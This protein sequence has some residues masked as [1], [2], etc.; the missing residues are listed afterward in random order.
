MKRIALTWRLMKGNWK[1][2]LL[3][4]A[5]YKTL[6]ILCFSP[7][8]MALLSLSISLSG[9][10]YIA[11]DNILQ[12]L[13]NPYAVVILLLLAF[14]VAMAALIE[15]CA[16][17]Y[18][19]HA[20]YHGEKVRV[21]E[22][23]R[24]GLAHGLRVF[25]QG[26][27]LLLIYVVVMLPFL[28]FGART[29][30]IASLKIPEFIMEYIQ[31]N[32]GLFAAYLVFFAL[33]MLFAMRWL[34]SLHYYTISELTFRDARKRSAALMHKRTLKTVV[35]LCLWGVALGFASIVGTVALLEI[36]ILLAKL[37]TNG[38][39][40]Y[41][42][43][44]TAVQAASGIGAVLS[45]PLCYAYIGSM[46]YTY[47]T[48]AGEA[49]LP[50]V[51]ME[52]RPGLRWL[53]GAIVALLLTAAIAL[54]TSNILPSFA[55]DVIVDR[56]DIQA[57]RGDSIAAPE[58]SMPA[59]LAAIEAGADW[60]ELDVH[61]TS[62]GVIVV[63]HDG[64]L[65]RIAGVNRHVWE[66]TYDELQQY[67]TGSW[68]DPK[69]DYVRVSTLEEVIQAAKGKIRLNIELKPTGHE[70]DFEAKVVQIV[71]DN[72]FVND[73]VLASLNYDSL[74]KVKAIDSSIQTLYIMAMAVGDIS[75]LGAADH[76]S[77]EATFVNQDLVER[78]HQGGHKIYVWTVNTEST[79]KAM[80]DLG[81]DGIITDDPGQMRAWVD[82][83]GLTDPFEW[84]IAM[85]IPAYEPVNPIVP[86]PSMD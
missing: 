67:D 29:G 42:L 76:F 17:L 69:F 53:G 15:I 19:F 14:L 1:A 9:T 10:A 44:H 70:P 72:D 21:A 22:M 33:L 6:S 65:K 75:T 73:C 85:Q 60:I 18:C 62:D 28:Q 46:F 34:F 43:G 31:N 30:Y 39:M 25:T 80:I 55:F 49:A 64:D 47:E 26:S 38:G 3:F 52:G 71:K 57:H 83:D 24:A 41:L 27:P 32:T 4:E 12:Y 7:A 5:C 54:G 59:F 68:F 51:R 37:L 82:G 11:G 81:V 63:T 74:V 13:S 50:F 16:L 77:V 20:A 23:L 8:L 58:N 61:Q 45:M 66:V 78:L 86:A 84:L 56:P 40:A 36:T 48:E 2:L 79:T 35:R